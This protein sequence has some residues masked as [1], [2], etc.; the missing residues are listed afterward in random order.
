MDKKSEIESE[1]LVPGDIIV[2]SEGEKVPADARLLEIE[3]S[4]FEVDESNLTGEPISVYK[5]SEPL[6]TNSEKVNVK[7]Q[8]NIIF[9][10]TGVTT[11]VAMAIV[12]NIG[13]DT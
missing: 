8:N 5:I 6:S 10:S 13:K 12:V 7:A 1:N 9:T 11:G 2:I 3:T 4:N